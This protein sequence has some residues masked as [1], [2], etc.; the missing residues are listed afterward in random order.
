MYVGDIVTAAL[1]QQMPFVVVASRD[2]LALLDSQ[3]GAMLWRRDV[4]AERLCIME[5]P[6]RIMSVSGGVMQSWRLTSGQMMWQHAETDKI[7][8]C[9]N[10]GIELYWLAGGIMHASDVRD[11]SMLWSIRV[12][13]VE[14]TIRA[15]YVSDSAITVAFTDLHDSRQLSVVAV[16]KSFKTMAS[17]SAQLQLPV[18]NEAILSEDAFMAVTEDSNSICSAEVTNLRLS[19]TCVPLPGTHEVK[20]RV[21]MFPAG[22]VVST[23]T[24]G[25]EAHFRYSI[26]TSGFELLKDATG[27]TSYLECPNGMIASAAVGSHANSI[28]LKVFKASTGETVYDVMLQ[29]SNFN[30]EEGNVPQMK[31]LWATSVTCRSHADDFRCTFCFVG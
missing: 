25:G 26:A 29:S 18:T 31:S 19:A 22:A 5:T 24:M 27:I 3:N 13:S 16:D 17:S 21:A 28:K 20:A 8:I 7:F 4:H 2:Q 9:C 1:P 12:M 15:C 30:F 10:D 23:A 6:D 11:G 14:G